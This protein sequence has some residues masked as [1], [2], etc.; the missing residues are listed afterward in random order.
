MT[1]PFTADQPFKEN[2]VIN[3]SEQSVDPADDAGKLVQL[4]AD[5]KFHP[6]FIKTLVDFGD[7]SDGDVT[8]STPTTLTRDMYY[9][10]LTVNDT[11]T[12]DGYRIFVKD[13]LDGTGT[14]T[15]GTPNPGSDGVTVNT[16]NTNPGAVGGAQSGNGLFKNVSGS[17]GGLGGFAGGG[18]D[19]GPGGDG[20]DIEAGNID[21]I[22]G[23][24]GN[25]TVGNISGAIATGGE[26]TL[27]NKI[28]T[29]SLYSYY[30]TGIGAVRNATTLDYAKSGAGAAGAGG[31][32]GSRA[33][34][35]GGGGGA[36]GGVIIIRCQTFAG[37]FS[38]VANG[39]N[40]GDG[41]GGAVASS[42]FG[43]NGGGGAGG[44]GGMIVVAF[45]K[46]T[47]TGTH[48]IAGG[49]GGAGGVNV[50]ATDAESGQ[51]AVSGLF[52]QLHI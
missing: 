7:G 44:A 14:I 24:G 33:G 36:S 48:N 6:T 42:N 27:E 35:P 21:L 9:N 43:G 25:G 4:E 8:I 23:D 3:E 29:D 26:S 2:N 40:G 10:N 15:W 45:N 16:L 19:F 38:L 18:F 32:G 5:G 34:G 39:A 30:L 31:A 1:A 17:N 51:D 47:W 20:Q 52:L 11:L 41:A 22:G 46:K 50:A 49:T 28:L 12:T 13:T 37:S